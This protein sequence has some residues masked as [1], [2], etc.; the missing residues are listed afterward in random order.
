MSLEDKTKRCPFCQPRE[1]EVFFSS[2]LVKG[3]WDT[4]PV[5]PGHALLVPHRHI[6]RWFDATAEE[7]VALTSAIE[8]AR[9]AIEERFSPQ[10]FNIGFNDRKAAGQSVPHLHIHVIPRYEGD[11]DY[12]RGGIRT[13][14]PARAAYWKEKE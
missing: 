12:P 2:E 11:V 10:G 5:N 3:V 1:G 9:A 8:K 14:I 13:I 6:A 7:Q 4:Y